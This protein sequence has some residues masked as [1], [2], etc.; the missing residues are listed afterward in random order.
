MSHN[1][2][3]DYVNEVKYCMFKGSLYMMIQVKEYIYIMYAFVFSTIPLQKYE[4]GCCQPKTMESYAY[5]W[6]RLHWYTRSTPG[7]S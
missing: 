6:T 2:F 4:D 7:I 1:I 5:Y 3:D